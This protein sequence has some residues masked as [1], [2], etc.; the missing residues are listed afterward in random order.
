MARGKDGGSGLSSP[1]PP[2]G[3]WGAPPDP[4]GTFSTE[5]SPPFPA[6]HPW[7]AEWA[8]AQILH[9]QVPGRCWRREELPA[10]SH[11]HRR[12]RSPALGAGWPPARP[13]PGAAV[14]NALYID[15]LQPL[16]LLNP[17]P[18]PA[19]FIWNSLPM[20]TPA[21]GGCWGAEMNQEPRL[22]WECTGN[23]RREGQRQEGVR[24]G[25]AVA[26]GTPKKWFWVLYWDAGPLCKQHRA[27][28][29]PWKDQLGK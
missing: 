25:L 1:S 13:A 5:H 27:G 17:S 19:G 29:S 12:G 9:R 28:C 8:Q 18:G 7:H 14:C 15:E 20:P 11:R 2:R 4:P 6:G 21:C 16:K 24:W 10:P 3:R 22:C 23:A 26:L